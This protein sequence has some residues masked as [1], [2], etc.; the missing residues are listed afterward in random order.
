MAAP[1]RLYNRTSPDRTAGI[2]LTRVGIDIGGTFTDLFAVA[3]SGRTWSAKVLTTPANPADGLLE[4]LDRWQAASG[5]REVREIVHATTVA[6]NAVLEGKTARL[7]LVTTAGFRDVLEIGRHQRR[8]LYNLFLEKPPVLVPRERRLEVRERIGADGSVIQPL[9]V[10]DVVRAAQALAGLETEAVV[11]AFLHSYAHP[12]HEQ[13]AA[14]VIARETG[15]PVVASHAVCREYR[16][17]ERFSTAAVHAAVLP[18]VA[19]YVSEIGSKLTA[20]GVTAPLSVM[21]SSGGMAPAA[22]VA[23]EPAS[24]VESGPAAG[25][26]AAAEVGRRLG[27]SN[28]ISFDMGGTST[29]ATLIR[30]GHVTINNDYEI[31]GGVH[32]G[33]GTGYPL[34]TPVID[35]VEI[36]T[37]GGSIAAVD[38]AG[39]LVVGPGSAGAEP[40]PACYGRGGARPTITDANAVLGRLRPDRFAG[41]HIRLDVDAA[42]R[43][44]AEHVAAP[45]GMSIER[46]AEGILALAG[47]QMG[48]ALEL[49]SVARGHDPRQFA[50]VAFGGAGP[51]HAADLAREL[52]CR[53]VVIPPEAGV[54]SAR[55]L[56]VAEARRDFSSAMLSAEV[57]L[58]LAE[59]GR[60]FA[61][62]RDRGARELGEAGFSAG[63]VS[64]RL[65]VDVRYKGQAYEVAVWLDEPAVFDAA[66]RQTVNREFHREHARLHGHRDDAAAIEWV[67]LR[68]SVTAGTTRPRP[69]ELAPPAEPL[70]DRRLAVQP[71]IWAGESLDAPVFARERLGRD[72]RVDGPA[73]VI[74]DQTTL[75]VPPA[76]LAHVQATGDIVLEVSAE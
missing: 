42:R 8:D 55:G 21:Q 56:L 28:V 25:V 43:A 19:T 31:G 33:F 9:D 38:A 36:G 26:I 47:A 60:R 64:A 14:E 54:Q 2:G 57:D 40:G 29:K 13:E 45:L 70:I 46:A 76:T 11:V 71:M 23:R 72:D 10:S 18:R 15:L 62:M 66:L 44:V 22:T 35:L 48:R 30:D 34:R 37:G 5:E 65:G 24:I 41:G 27:V 61:D 12:Q 7:G 32:G 50:M 75:V 3:D 68:A 67:A 69:T 17:Y 6:T 49:V 52:G 59:A 51:M 1:G 20:R 63:A 53:Q 58:D 4:V 39:S 16:E 74:Q 73:L